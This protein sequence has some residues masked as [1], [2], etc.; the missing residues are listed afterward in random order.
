MIYCI[1]KRKQLSLFSLCFLMWIVSSVPKS[2]RELRGE[3]GLRRKHQRMTEWV[4]SDTFLYS[5]T[6]SPCLLLFFLLLCE[7][8][9]TT[10][11]S[12]PPVSRATCILGN[13]IPMWDVERIT[14]SSLQGHKNK[15]NQMSSRIYS[16]VW[17]NKRKSLWLDGFLYR[18]MQRTHRHKKKTD[19]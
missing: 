14:G 3:Y 5:T 4:K 12:I 15:E 13:I 11:L 18:V 19:T 10:T 7:S 9:R 6:R 8:S 16:L 1:A 2:S 17:K